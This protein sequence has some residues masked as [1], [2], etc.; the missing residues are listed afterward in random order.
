MGITC[1]IDNVSLINYL[2]KLGLWIIL[3][4]INI[5][6]NNYV[7]RAINCRK[8]ILFLFFVWLFFVFFET[9]FRCVTLAILEL[10]L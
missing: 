3:S 8:F 10:A 1:I 9:E 5:H 4:Q 2:T 7:N 6:S